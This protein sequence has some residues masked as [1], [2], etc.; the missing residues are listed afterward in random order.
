MVD[1]SQLMK[2]WDWTV[3]DIRKGALWE[4]GQIGGRWQARM[5]LEHF[6]SF[7]NFGN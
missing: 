5:V 6:Q 4:P 1:G 7:E 3:N 2:R